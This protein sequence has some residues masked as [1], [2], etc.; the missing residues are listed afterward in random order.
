MVKKS[1][2]TTKTP[3]KAAATFAQ[4]GFPQTRGNAIAFPALTEVVALLDTMAP[5]HLAEPWDKVGLLS[6]P[7]AACEVRRVMVALDLT[8]TVKERC[9]AM[10]VNL[11]VSYH[12]PL[13]K[14][15]ERLC[16]RGDTPADLAVELTGEKISIYS[17]HTALDVAVGGTNDALAARLQLSP[18]G[19]L[20]LRQQNQPLLKLVVFVPESHLEQVAEAVFQAGAGQIGLESRYTQCS[21]RT[22]GTGTFFGDETTSPAVGRRGR[23]ELVPEIRLETVV[24]ESC[25]D[26]V[27]A[28]LRQAHPYEE[29]AFDLLVMRG[30]I[31]EPGMGRIADL[32]EAMPLDALARRCKEKLGLKAVQVVGNA[33]RPITTVGLLAGSCGTLPLQNSVRIDCVITG[34]LKHHDMLAF[35]AAGVAAI[36][37]GHAESEKPVLAVLAEKL[38]NAFPQV[39][40]VRAISDVEVCRTL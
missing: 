9:L 25:V 5:T 40:V 36:M 2:S 32:P 7:R 19:S 23:L 12:P 22:P 37:L 14:P 39:Q 16:V 17:P 24:P 29:P 30:E 35:E 15:L 6:A 1:R 31:G 38:A 34:E 4:S 26:A 13:F 11:L 10:N 3:R 27:T 28:A 21:F 20:L 8:A 18:R 33:T